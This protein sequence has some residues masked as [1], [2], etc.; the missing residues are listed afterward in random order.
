MLLKIFKD[1]PL[2]VL[3]FGIVFSVVLWA[4]TI[5]RLGEITPPYAGV[6]LFPSFFERANDL[7]WLRAVLGLTLLVLQAATWNR[8][9]NKHGLLKQAGYF[10]FFFMAILL[11]CRPSLIGIY[12]APVSSL[13]LVLAIHKIIS[14][15]K[16]EKALSEIFDAGLFIGIASLFYIPSTLFIVLLWI[17][18]ITVRTINLR[19]WV[20][21]IIGF[22][23][24]FVFMFT[25][26]L[27]FYP[28]YS[29]FGKITGEFTYHKV[30]ISFSWEQITIMVILCL[31]ALGSLW[32]F[33]NRLTDNVVKTQKFWALMLWFILIA[34]GSVLICP[35]KDSRTLS[36]FVIPGSFIL[37]AYFLKTRA[38]FL[39]E[40]LFLSLLAGVI[41]SMFF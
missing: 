17:G 19:E 2:I 4:V 6:T 22:S 30:H 25:Y 5:F 28:G 27:V 26:N 39:P 36:V 23:L 31:I 40:I 33:V 3:I 35:V 13:F 38:K 20:C 16:N 24:P 10:P 9:V 8:I 21:T 12:P 37:S 29:W 7:P 34:V 11:S 14:S 32:F 15:Y 18:L 41:V 1:N